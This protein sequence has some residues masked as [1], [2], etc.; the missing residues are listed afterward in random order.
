MTT[1]PQQRHDTRLAL[2][3]FFLTP[4]RRHG[5]VDHNRE[6]SFLELFYDLVYVVIIGQAAHHLATH[7]SWTGLRDFVAVFG[8][9]WLAWFNGT[10]WHE[11]HGREDGRS[12]TNI[13][14]QMGLI[15]LMAVYTGHATE[16]DG[17][18]FATVYLILFAWYTYQWFAVHRVDDPSYRPM[19]TQYLVAMLATMA[20]IGV[21][22]AL[23]DDARVWL[24]LGIV[25]FWVLGGF[26]ATATERMGDFGLNVTESMVERFG[27][28]TIVVLGEVVIGVVEGL[29]EAEE[30]SAMTIAVAM[31]GLGVGMGLWWNYFDALGRRVPTEPGTR[32][33]G[34]LYIHFPLTTALAASGAAMVSLIEHAEDGRTPGAT[35][36]LLSGS[37]A[38][39]LGGIALATR[40]LP[41]DM[42]PDGFFQRIPR[43][44]GVGAVLAIAIGA[45]RPAPIVLTGGLLAVLAATWFWLI[46]QFF[47][48]GGQ[49]AGDEPGI[50]LEA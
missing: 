32:L 45:A 42:Y 21:S 4:P 25:G 8:L 46:V 37:V 22:I 26:A 1:Q 36:W 15:A 17:P 12:R 43:T 28:F 2:R 13:F 29:S 49:P 10:L 9:I 3:R 14:I 19:T 34:W 11:L 7:V 33:A 40:A 48:A 44:L 6:V 31:L 5:E 27:L 38:I 18:G 30:R 16:E 41:H 20:A 39:T 47:A 24:W 35:A 50:E 23:P